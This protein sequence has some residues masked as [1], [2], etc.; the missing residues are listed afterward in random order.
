MTRRL[1][2]FAPFATLVLAAGCSDDEGTAP[3]QAPIVTYTTRPDSGAVVGSEVRLAWSAVDPDGAVA[4]YQTSLDSETQFQDTS[5]TTTVL[6]FTKA[7]GS[8]GNPM[9]HVFRVRAV[10]N[11]GLAGAAMAAAF[12]VA[13][14]ND[15]PQV[16]LTTAPASGKYAGASVTFGWRG[17]DTDGTV[18]GYE[19]VFDDT[20]AVWT[21]IADTTVTVD[22]SADIPQFPKPGLR[23]VPT[24]MPRQYTFFVRAVDNE[25]KR[26]RHS[27]VTFF[28]G[29]ENKPPTLTLDSAP[30]L[31]EEGTVTGA[32]TWTWTTQ[33]PDG[34]ILRTQYAI[35]LKS[36]SGWKRWDAN[37]ITLNFTR[38]DGKAE[39][40]MAH[41][42]HLR[43]QDDDSLY[44]AVIVRDFLVGVPN[45][46]PTVVFTTKPDSSAT[47]NYFFTYVWQGSDDE[48]V[49]GYEY[50]VDDS[51][52]GWTTTVA[53]S[54]VVVFS[55]ANVTEGSCNPIA[56]C[57]ATGDHLFFLR[58]VDGAGLRSATLR[59]PIH[60]FNRTPVTTI[61]SP[62][63]TGGEVTGSTSF[64]L[65]WQGADVGA[66]AE[67]VLRYSVL[68]REVDDFANYPDATAA[69]TE[70]GLV[71][72]SLGTVTQ[73][74]VTLE[75]GKRYLVA[76]RALDEAQAVESFFT[77][78]KDVLKVTVP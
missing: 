73:T 39:N 13:V 38:A 45:Q 48:G 49:A 62:T 17:T 41:S 20:T 76:V 27:G 50:A 5:D 6:S 24:H 26:S 75:S 78:G 1:V 10:D 60:T 42:F 33:D 36:P 58:A 57:V 23:V 61:T 67:Q 55:T 11:R 40:P 52:G 14:F 51:S 7:D 44:S 12:T 46:A 63:G 69:V 25:G 64:A 9:P 21:A 43:T 35:D 8:D 70:P 68:T 34:G 65:V 37:S 53:T 19:V 2:W 18:N 30:P 74:T 59:S 16:V 3:N 4:G 72:Q 22:F 31:P 15:P 32:A 71:W 47:V 66:R 54:Q 77:Y 29:P 28:A 56:G